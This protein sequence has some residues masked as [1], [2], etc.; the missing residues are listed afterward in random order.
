M[1]L[2]KVTIAGFKSFADPTEFRFDMPITG[3]VG[4]N[5]CGK[6]NVVDAIKWVL[7]ERSAKSLRGDAMLDVV[8][9]GSAA[10]KPLGAASVTLTFDNPIVEKKSQVS[11]FKS[12]IDGDLDAGS[13][14]P[15]AASDERSPRE[16]WR[17]EE[18]GGRAPLLQP[19]SRRFLPIES[20]HVSVTR[21]LYRDGHS[22]YLIND[23]KCRLRDI[24][25]LFM[26]TGIGTH[27]YS[28]IEQGRVDAML[29]ANPIER[30]AILEEAAGVAKFKARKIEAA[31]KL[32]R[33][34]VNLVRVREELANT[35]RRLRIVKGQA[36]K[37]RKFREMDARYRQLRVDLALDLYHELRE[38]LAGLTSQI[39]SLETKRHEMVQML[40]ALED[41][42][43][44]AEIGRH[45][46]QLQQRDLEQQRLE[47]GAGRK[48][49]EQRR[50]LTQRNI[51]EAQQ[52]LADD[53]SRLATLS[54]KVDT[55]NAEIARAHAAIADATQ[56]VAAAE[57]LVNTL[58]DQR[59]ALQ[60]AIVQA[61][62]HHEHAVE[63]ASRTA[64]VKSQLAGRLTAFDARAN[65][66]N[67]Q[68][69]KLDARLTQLDAESKDCESNRARSDADLQAAAVDTQSLNAQLVEHDRAAAALGEKQTQLTERLADARHHRAALASRL[70]LLDEM[71]QAREGL[72]DAVKTV[73]N[74]PDRFPAVRGLL[75]DAID[76]DRQHVHLVEAA[77][78]S[79]LELLLVNTD[80]DVS[81]LAPLIGQLQGR[82]SLLSI[83]HPSLPLERE[84]AVAAT[85][86]EATPLLSLINT[87]PHA[88]EAVANLLRNTF[89]VQDLAIALSLAATHPSWRFVTRQAEVVESDGR[90]TCGR[91]AVEGAT[92]SG[93][94]GWL[95]RRI[96]I[97]ELRAKVSELDTQVGSLNAELESLLSQSAQAEQTQQTLDSRLRAAQH[98]VVEIQYQTQRLGN[99]FAR[100]HREH[101]ALQAEQA[102]VAQRLDYLSTERRD[103]SQKLQAHSDAFVQQQEA[104]AAAHSQLQG[105]QAKFDA[106]QEHLTA[107]KVE[108]GQA[109]Q[110]LETARREHRHLELTLEDSTS[111]LELCRQQVHRRLSQ[112]EQYEAVIA[113]A[114]Q[115]IV[116]SDSRLSELGERQT[117][118][119]V[120]LR[121]AADVV[122]QA[123]DR[124]AAARAQASH[125]DRDY[126]AVE[127]S[128]REAEVKRE[129]LE[130]RT[131]TDLEMDLSQ[132]YVPYRSTRE[133]DGFQP[134]DREAAQAEIDGL[135]ED[136]RKLGNVNLDAIQEETLLEE[137]NVDLIKQVHDI[138][139]A[140][141]QLQSLIQHLDESSRK[142]FEGVFTSI[143]EHFAGEA[144]M[145]RKL[146]GGGQADIMLLPDEQGNIDWLESGIEVRAKPPGKEPRVISQLSGGEK[147]MTAVALLMA[148]FKSKPSPFCILDEVDA[149][150]DDANVDRFCKILVPFLD[151]SHFI[152]ITHHKRTMQACDQLYGVTMQERG[153]SKRVAVRVEEVA[154]DGKIHQSAINRADTEGPGTSFPVANGQVHEPPVIDT[155]PSR[156]LH[157][158]EQALSGASEN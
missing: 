156:K 117:A 87:Q 99:D 90:I 106:A 38:R 123:A 39:S 92:L 57:Q 9:A 154:H 42:K 109:G 67:E 138:D 63:A 73:L 104:A 93:G 88:R 147:A 17:S 33:S 31:R 48:H 81:W 76:T 70:H 75:A 152:I 141:N 6:S 21:R 133:E 68:L 145:F 56:R 115:D 91:A 18:D 84:I 71:H 98:K 37:A 148:I 134:I 11:D 25:E 137:R 32:E 60:Q 44:Q 150:L 97:A 41:Q 59:S 95:S 146:F 77:L 64:H 26:D 23:H 66:L 153:V 107:A 120:Q 125:I 140:V 136:I 131:L 144:G 27:A 121:A 47:L 52:Q 102:D 143:R 28:I 22:E 111:Q 53:R 105:A 83:A 72:A 50:D 51:A 19:S 3:I 24:K 158:L 122:A 65:S 49:A 101:S 10:R 149:A 1:R 8:F 13:D 78:G 157:Q 100:I 118:L 46:L 135:R 61:K 16:A 108:L 45:D 130:E 79:N 58:S 113:E 30:R 40:A 94:D 110:I 15:D 5:G 74:D 2:A 43:Q 36:V 112:I 12:Q 4:P 127:L 128:R 54:T 85:V 62:D 86:T 116:R 124:L 119:H 142:R 55:L 34:E 29:M 35:E 126:H 132:A 20:P 14:D 7:G 69:T 89:M 151:N 114:D 103:L 139:T 82:V 129:N 96:E 155:E 80:G